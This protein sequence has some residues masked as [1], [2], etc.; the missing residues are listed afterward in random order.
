[1]LFIQKVGLQF[2]TIVFMIYGLINFLQL[3]LWKLFFLFFFI[4]CSPSF[5]NLFPVKL[6]MYL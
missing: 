1:M 3:Q 5:Q 6:H 4:F 2:K